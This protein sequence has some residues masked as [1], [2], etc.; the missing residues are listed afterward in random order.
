MQANQTQVVWTVVIA[1]IVLLVVG[2]FSVASVNNNLKAIDIDEA[3]LANAIVAGI[4]IPEVTIPDFPEYE[5]VDMSKVNNVWCEYFGEETF[6]DTLETTAE[7]EVISEFDSDAVVLFLEGSGEGQ[8]N[9]L[10]GFY[11]IV[12]KFKLDN[13]ETNVDIVEG[14][15]WTCDKYTKNLEVHNGVDREVIVTL[16]Y[17]FNYLRID[18]PVG[19]E[20]EGTLIVTGTYTQKYNEDDEIYEDAE[21]EFKYSFLAI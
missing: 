1:A 4:V 19:D 8:L 10:H 20:Y 2:L 3:A 12:G 6:M 13:E 21:V 11:K 14:G 9:A 15:E 17:N 5:E 16:T 18:E 7:A